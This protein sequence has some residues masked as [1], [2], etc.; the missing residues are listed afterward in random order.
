MTHDENLV[1]VTAA[2]SVESG[3][4]TFSC[5]YTPDYALRFAALTRG[6]GLGL[7]LVLTPTG[8][9]LRSAT[10]LLLGSAEQLFIWT[11]EHLL[12]KQHWDFAE[13]STAQLCEALD[14]FQQE[15]DYFQKRANRGTL[16]PEW[17]ESWGRMKEWGEAARAELIRRDPPPR[18][19]GC[20]E[21]QPNQLAHMEP[22]GCCYV[23]E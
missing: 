2:I 22:G 16:P 9:T 7:T 19:W 12:Q 6:R 21:D 10:P 5:A 15:N 13:R 1:H 23:E 14:E 18:C 11:P 20:A 8:G 3:G 17:A 4:G